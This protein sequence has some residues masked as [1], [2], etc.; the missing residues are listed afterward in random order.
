ELEVPLV[1]AIQVGL[2]DVPSNLGRHA[3]TLGGDFARPPCHDGWGNRT[4]GKSE[5]GAPSTRWWPRGWV[6]MAAALAH[7]L[8]YAP[9]CIEAIPARERKRAMMNSPTL[10]CLVVMTGTAGRL[11]S[12][13]PRGGDS[14]AARAGA[15]APACAGVLGSGAS[16]RAADPRS[17][18]KE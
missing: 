15:G 6:T 2:D 4:D 1:L 3:A 7:L 5:P 10:K 12:A 11:P 18:V 17:A 13:S 8:T 14:G 9:P 16:G